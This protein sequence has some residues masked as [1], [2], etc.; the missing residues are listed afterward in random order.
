M[1]NVS[2][3]YNDVAEVLDNINLYVSFGETVAI[4]GHSG[5]GK[6]TLC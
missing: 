4:V 6:T 3:A 5:G 1:E 2:F